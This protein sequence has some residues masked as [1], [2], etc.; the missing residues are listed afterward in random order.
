MPTAPSA[1]NSDWRFRA[2]QLSQKACC[3]RWSIRI[4][5]RSARLAVSS[6]THTLTKVSNWIVGMDST[7]ELVVRPRAEFSSS[8]SMHIE[9]LATHSIEPTFAAPVASSDVIL[10]SVAPPTATDATTT[11][12]DTILKPM[13]RFI[14][15]F[16]EKCT[17]RCICC[18]IRLRWKF[19]LCSL[20]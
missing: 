5:V 20:I 17:C 4:T 12:G 7:M 11:T 16:R 10:P 8:T 1:S 13:E 3:A 14:D 18:S 6:I 15:K 2:T 9:E 19:L